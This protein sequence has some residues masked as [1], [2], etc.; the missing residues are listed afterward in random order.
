MDYHI[1]EEGTEIKLVDLELRHLKNIIGYIEKKSVEG[2]EI[3][4]SNWGMANYAENMFYDS[5]ICYGK[6]VKNVLNYYDYIKELNRRN[7]FKNTNNMSE[8]KTSKI[9]LI[10]LVKEHSNSHGKIY[11]HN[12]Q[13]ENGD[14]INIGKKNLQEKGWE[15]TYE[16]IGEKKDDGTY[17]EIYPRAKYA[18]K[19]QFNKPNKYSQKSSG[20]DTKGV[21]VG[22]AIN[23]AVNMIC[24][25]VSFDNVDPEMPS[26]KKIKAYARNILLIS[27]Q[28][29]E[30]M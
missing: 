29:K 6:E 24:A 18:Q 8:I 9:R 28:L 2:L 19:E 22:H 12:L 20:Y 11:Y 21:E 5:D 17:Q 26:G 10:D 4:M 13:M 16:I 7:N 30:E 23:N 14:K 1:T 25:G 27:K 15:L 3:S